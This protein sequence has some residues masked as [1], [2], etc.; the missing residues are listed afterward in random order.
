[1]SLIPKYRDNCFQPNTYPALDTQQNID[2]A[3]REDHLHT[4]IETVIHICVAPPIPASIGVPNSGIRQSIR[5]Q[6]NDIVRVSPF[7]KTT[8]NKINNTYRD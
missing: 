1:M 2:K 5:V 3:F 8:Y 6:H 7:I 4:I